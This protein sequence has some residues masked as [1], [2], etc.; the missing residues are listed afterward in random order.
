MT[1]LPTTIDRLRPRLVGLAG[2]Y[3]YAAS[4]IDQMALSAFNFALNLCLV[5]ALSATDFGIVSLWIAASGLAIGAQ[6]ALVNTPLCVYLP[7]ASDPQQARRLEQAIA[8]VNLLT[9]V[10]TLAVVVA[11]ILAVDAEWAPHDFL[12]FAAIPLFIAACM[13]REY[14]RS[15]AFSR[16]D[17]AMLLWIDVPYLIGTSLGLMAMLVWPQYLATLAGA[18]L[19]MSLGCIISRLLVRPAA[20]ERHLNPFRR[21]WAAA[22]R[23]IAGEV[24]WSLVGVGATHLQTRGYIYVTVNLVGLAGLAAINVVGVL[25]RPV[26]TMLTAWGRSA[27]PSMAALLAKNDLGAFD[28]AVWQAFAVATLASAGWFA[29]LWLGWQPIETYF[30]AG[31]YPDAWDLMWPWAIAAALNSMEYTIGIA[32]QAL[33]E[34]KFL[35]TVT[36]LSAPV[37]AAA[38]AGA[39]LWQG[40]TW[41]MYGVALGSL[42]TL[43]LEIGR[44]WAARRRLAAPLG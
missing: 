28:R 35:A 36:L 31:K 24:T 17:M 27:L 43:V 11:T 29:V 41:T 4:A 33:R 8:I 10:L 5:R 12:G 3:R 25:F 16:H 6:N 9:T 32:L 39:V 34:F 21:G 44:V 20:G 1:C 42:A 23:R 19:A 14:Y 15:I 22:Y 7:A 38:T 37:T 13:Y 40:Y 18:F 2:R 30:L 26:R